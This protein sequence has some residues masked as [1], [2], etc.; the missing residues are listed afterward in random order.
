[1][2]E[3]AIKAFV[4]LLL[5]S[6]LV[7]GGCR[8]QRRLDAGDIASEKAKAEAMRN[9]LREAGKAL[10][11]AAIAFR[12]IDAQAKQQADESTRRQAEADNAAAAA[13]KDA[14][15]FRRKLAELQSQT[16][17]DANACPQARMTICGSP[18]R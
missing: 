15:T 9:N 7:F 11:D 12:K 2:N 8:W 18:L 17:R 6:L 4:L 3:I 14:D 10:N 16:V 13:R 5:S 1:M